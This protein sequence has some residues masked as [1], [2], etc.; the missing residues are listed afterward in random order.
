MQNH[1][2]GIEARATPTAPAHSP[3]IRRAIA[4]T[5]ASGSWCLPCRS[6]DGDFGHVLEWAEPVIN[7]PADVKQATQR[8]PGA[9]HVEVN[10]GAVASDDV[11]KM[12]RMSERESCEV[13]KRV[14]L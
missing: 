5:G 2:I 1:R 10:I 6:Q 4:T 3:N 12:L 13:E 7:E 11:I 14:A 9:D 8:S